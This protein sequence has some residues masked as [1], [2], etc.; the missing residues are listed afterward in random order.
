[1]HSRTTALVASVNLKHDSVLQA[2]TQ[3]KPLL[4]LDAHSRAARSTMQEAQDTGGSQNARAQTHAAYDKETC[5]STQSHPCSEPQNCQAACQM[6][7]P[8]SKTAPQPTKTRRQAM[9]GVLLGAT[10]HCTPAYVCCCSAMPLRF[11]ALHTRGTS[12]NPQRSTH[13]DDPHAT[14]HHSVPPLAVHLHKSLCAHCTHAA[15]NPYTTHRKQARLTC[16]RL[17]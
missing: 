2:S 12:G 3:P 17:F 4:L 6:Q 16:K 9:H 8:C 14:N 15:V 11:I 7:A 13:T 1:M 10:Q 5:P